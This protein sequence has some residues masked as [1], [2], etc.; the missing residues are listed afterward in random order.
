M[1]QQAVDAERL[2]LAQCQAGAYAIVSRLFR[3]PLETSE[4]LELRDGDTLSHLAEYTGVLG[5]ESSSAITTMR[6]VLASDDMESVTRRLNIEAT[7]LFHVH[8][9]EPP[10]VPFESVWREPDRLTMGRSALLVAEI[11][12][13]NGAHIG[14]GYGD[15]APDH[16]AREMEF[17]SHAAREE[18][19]ALERGDSIAAD[20]WVGVAEDFVGQHLRMWLPRFFAAIRN[21][22]SSEFFCAVADLGEAL[23]LES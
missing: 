5:L 2:L 7:R 23:L 13:R 10:A 8:L 15:A 20:R 1:L 11:Y 18:A 16:V 19:L 14:H 6:L 4:L 12:R 21:D 3:T 22:N 9:P 17:V